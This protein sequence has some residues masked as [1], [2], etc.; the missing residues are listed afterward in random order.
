MVKNT[1]K[2]THILYTKRVCRYTK[3]FTAATTTTT[4]T[5]TDVYLVV[6]EP[7]QNVHLIIFNQAV[8]QWLAVNPQDSE[9]WPTQQTGEAQSHTND[10]GNLAPRV[11]IKTVLL[12]SNIGERLSYHDRLKGDAESLAQSGEKKR[13]RE[14][15]VHLPPSTCALYPI[16]SDL[17]IVVQQFLSCVSELQARG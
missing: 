10:R 7:K 14:L 12:L 11:Q 5:T 9:E 17:S 15:Q 8:K 13:N 3:T 1:L 4:T 6:S 16:L 2:T